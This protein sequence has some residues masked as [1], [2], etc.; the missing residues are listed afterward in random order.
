VIAEG[1][2]YEKASSWKLYR[3]RSAGTERLRKPVQRRD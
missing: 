2:E 3:R 1:T